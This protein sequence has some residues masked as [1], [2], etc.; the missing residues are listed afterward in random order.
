MRPALLLAD[1]PTGALDT[2]TG[3]E[4]MALFQRLHDQGNTIVLVTHEHDIAQHAHRIVFIRDGKIVTPPLGASVL[5]GITRDSVITLAR[6]MGIPV[7]EALV[8]REMLYI[9]DEVF[10]TGTAA[11]VTP[12]R[13]V[14][15][16]AIGT[17]QRGPITEK[18][19][20]AFKRKLIPANTM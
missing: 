18:L 10:F 9:A 15:G 17:G 8:P 4:I 13:E 11:E 6:E 19:Q 1:E 12:I 14:D 20:K 7:V 3:I 5:P 16:R 2:Q